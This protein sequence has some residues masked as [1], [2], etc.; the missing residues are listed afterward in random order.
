M[1][2]GPEPCWVRSGITLWPARVTL[3]KL[4]HL[5]TLSWKNPGLCHLLRTE[6]NSHPS[7]FLTHL[8]IQDAFPIRRTRSAFLPGREWRLLTSPAPDRL[9]HRFP[10]LGDNPEGHPSWLEGGGQSPSEF[11]NAF[12][13]AIQTLSW[14]EQ[15]CA[16][17]LRAGP[18]RSGRQEAEPGAFSI[19]TWAYETSLL[20]SWS[21]CFPHCEAEIKN[22]IYLTGTLW[23]IS[24]CIHSLHEH[25]CLLHL[26]Q[27][28]SKS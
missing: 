21:L 4:I 16:A 6:A 10:D 3:S 19:A 27:V 5:W 12:H 23:V 7:N 2:I 20:A 15:Q 18:L 14:H 8:L 26:W 1:C 24:V 25:A 9:T 28:N 17:C 22:S 11:S 13:Q